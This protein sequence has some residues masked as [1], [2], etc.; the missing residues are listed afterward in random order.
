MKILTQIPAWLRNKYFVAFGVFAAIMLFFDKND[1]AKAEVA[2][3][4]LAVKDFAAK[5]ALT[6][7]LCASK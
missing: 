2:A 7:P 5:I 6:I 1:D 3:V 4:R